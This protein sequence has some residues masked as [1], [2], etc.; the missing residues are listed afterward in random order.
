MTFHPAI[1]YGIAIMTAF[2]VGCMAARNRQSGWRKERNNDVMDVLMAWAEAHSESRPTQ[3]SVAAPAVA[4]PAPVAPAPVADWSSQLVALTA[5]LNVHS[6]VAPA[7]QVDEP[8]IS[9]AQSV[10]TSRA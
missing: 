5:A 1:G 10:T 3:Q 6:G 8:H 4:A 7:S 2:V 9:V